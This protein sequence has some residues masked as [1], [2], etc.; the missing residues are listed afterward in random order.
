MSQRNVAQFLVE[1]LDAW[2]VQTV[3]GVPGDAILPFLDAI[4]QHPRLKFISVKHESTAAFMASAEAKLMNRLGVCVATSGPGTANLINGLADAKNDRASVLAITGQ[5]DSFNLGTD[6]KQAIDQNQLL[7]AVSDYSGLVCVPESCNDIVMTAMRIALHRGTVAH[8]AFTKDIWQSRTEEPVRTPELY[9]KT[10][11]QSPPEVIGEAIRRL[12]E[13]E[14]P[15]ILVGRGIKNNSAKVLELAQKWQAGICVSMPARGL[16]Y[17]DRVMG[18][19]GE[20]GSEASS[21]M[22]MEADLILIMGTTWWPPKAVPTDKRIIQLDAAPENIGR[23]IPVEY[24]VAGDLAVLLPQLIQGIVLKEKPVW[25]NRLDTYK[26]RWTEVIHGE[27]QPEQNAVTPGYLIKALEQTVAENAIICLD[28][29]D[30][31]IWFNR[32]FNGSHQDVL[33]SGSWRTMGFGL[34]AALSAKLAQPERQVVALTGDGGFA[35]NMGDFL[36]AVRYRLPVSV[37]IM[38]NGY[39]AMERDK[40]VKLKLDSELTQIT[41]PDFARFGQACGGIG[42]RVE[43]PGDLEDA[44]RQAIQSQRP[45]IVDVVTVPVIFPMPKQGQQLQKELAMV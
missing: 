28:V 22:L 29:G 37:V 31:A 40:M 4:N 10:I 20:G 19:L 45:A 43:R 7:A 36:T 16:L 33:I 21:A 35:M 12:N 24:G 25:L 26:R 6:Y 18:G 39:L 5:V 42:L 11:A 3:Y 34:P 13:A 41:N 9:L 2:G 1:Q 38:N 32:I 23:M 15:A 30:N 8:V 17:G 14:R 27:T 44:L